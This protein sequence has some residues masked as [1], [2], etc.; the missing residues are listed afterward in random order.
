[1]S[2]NGTKQTSISTPDMSAFGDKADTLIGW[3]MSADD[4]NRTLGQHRLARY[5]ILAKGG[6]VQL[7]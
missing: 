4:P 2:A 6:C 5:R 3:P 1:M 7:I